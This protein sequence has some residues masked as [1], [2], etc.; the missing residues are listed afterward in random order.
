MV[1]FYMDGKIS[2][3]F[4]CYK[5]NAMFMPCFTVNSPVLLP[6]AV[7]WGFRDEFIGKGG[8]GMESRYLLQAICTYLQ[9][10]R[11]RVNFY[12]IVLN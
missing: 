3:S 2:T 8:K 6:T 1:K 10:T 12:Q 4:S 11:T 5:H 7:N 9:P